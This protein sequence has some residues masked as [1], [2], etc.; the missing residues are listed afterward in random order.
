MRGMKLDLKEHLIELAS[1]RQV[2]ELICDLVDHYVARSDNKI[3][4][5]MAKGLRAAMFGDES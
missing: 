4:D 2:K 1:S 3:D 5:R